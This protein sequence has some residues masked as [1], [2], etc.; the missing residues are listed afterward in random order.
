MQ[1]PDNNTREALAM[2]ALFASVGVRS[3]DVT[4]TDIEGEKVRYQVNRSVD[5]L[6]HTIDKALHAAINAKER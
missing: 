3:F 6:W 2:F 5:V 1:E 4:F